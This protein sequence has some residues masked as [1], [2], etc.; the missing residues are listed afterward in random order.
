VRG[1]STP[2]FRPGNSLGMADL[3][4]FGAPMVGECTP[5]VKTWLEPGGIVG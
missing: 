2:G 3:P 5:R 4:V 1:E